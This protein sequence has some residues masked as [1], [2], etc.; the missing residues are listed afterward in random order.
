VISHL[1]ERMQIRSFFEQSAETISGRTGDAASG[2]R[3]TIARNIVN[4]LR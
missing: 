1:E 4:I 2:L 3:R